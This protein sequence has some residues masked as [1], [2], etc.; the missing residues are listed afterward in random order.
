MK[1]LPHAILPRAASAKAIG[2][3]AWRGP[4]EWRKEK[5]QLLPDMI[6]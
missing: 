3:A 2:W 5:K 4:G 6:H 1:Q